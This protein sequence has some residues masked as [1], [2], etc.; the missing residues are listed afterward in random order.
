MRRAVAIAVLLAAACAS[1]A[2]VAPIHVRYLG[3]ATFEPVPTSLVAVV[4]GP[5][6]R[7][8]EKV[9]QLEVGDDGTSYG[10]LVERLRQRAGRVGANAIVEVAPIYDDPGLTI[11]DAS[12]DLAENTTTEAASAGVSILFRR[13][14][15]KGVRAVAVRRV[16]AEPESRP[17]AEKP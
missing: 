7:P 4:R 3:P 12:S 9:A 14:V 1:R 8:H 15:F 16:D 13:P 5:E 6:T 2:K 11:P 10:E 17:A